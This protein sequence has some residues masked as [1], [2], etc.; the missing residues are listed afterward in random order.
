MKLKLDVMRQYKREIKKNRGEKKV[1]MLV[2][3]EPKSNDASASLKT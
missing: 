3:K 1:Q 2:F